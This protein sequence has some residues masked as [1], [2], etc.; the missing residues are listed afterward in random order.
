[1]QNTQQPS[2]SNLTDIHNIPS[3]LRT[4]LEERIKMDVYAS[5]KWGISIERVIEIRQYGVQLRKKFPHMSELRICKKIAEHFKIEL[6]GR[7]DSKD[8]SLR[9]A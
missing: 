8:T 9:K 2:N 6:I 7:L 3:E 4:Q 5:K 1:M